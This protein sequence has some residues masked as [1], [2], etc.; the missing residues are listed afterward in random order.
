M[1]GRER[2]RMP[3]HTVRRKGGIE[4]HDEDKTNKHDTN[5]WRK[6]VKAERMTAGQRQGKRTN[7]VEL[8]IKRV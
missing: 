4:R 1:V 6:V 8:L 5:Q 2:R 3:G 7:V